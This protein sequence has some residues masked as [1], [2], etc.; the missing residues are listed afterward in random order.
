MN[1]FS[2]ALS[3]LPNHCRVPS[4]QLQ[5]QQAAAYYDTYNPISQLISGNKPAG[6]AGGHKLLEQQQQQQQS[7]DEWLSSIKMA[8]YKENF[9]RHQISSLQYVARLSQADLNLIGIENSQHLKKILN[10]I[11]SLRS[12]ASIGSSG[13]GYLV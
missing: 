5:E 9:Q 7:V 2:F 10:A 4:L 11:M 13:E 8:K 12:S 6:A 1:H 3:Q